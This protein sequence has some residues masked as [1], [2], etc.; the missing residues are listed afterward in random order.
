[1]SDIGFLVVDP[2]KAIQTFMRQTLVGYGFQATGIKT[3]STPEEAQGLVARDHVDFLLSDWFEG[4]PLNGIGLYQ[5]LR[6]SSHDCRFA[7]LSA[8]VD[9]DRQKEASDAGS[10]FLLGKPFTA[11]QLRAELIRTLEK[12]AKT[13]LKL[14]RHVNA[15]PLQQAPQ[16]ALHVP[17]VHLPHFKQ[18]DMVRYKDRRETVAY[19]ILRH[20]ELVVQLKGIPGLIDS[21][22]IQPL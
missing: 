12:L 16:R 3:A 11:D 2:S 9:P 8:K 22:K 17:D 19:V 14:V 20:G 1:M 4:A 6:E 21:H 13:H 18:G 7:L 10:L 15:S 5:H